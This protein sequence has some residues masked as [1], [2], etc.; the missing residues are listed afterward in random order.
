M[1]TFGPITRNIKNIKSMSIV[2]LESHNNG[3]LKWGT[4]RSSFMVVCTKR[5]YKQQTT[6]TGRRKA[7]V[8]YFGDELHLRRLKWIATCQSK[9][10]EISVTR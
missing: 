7:C 3:F 9:T 10:T 1:A 4:L 8:P 2:S 6:G 5:K